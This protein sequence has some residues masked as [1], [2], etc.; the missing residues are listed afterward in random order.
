MTGQEVL[1]F[2]NSLTEE[3]LEKPVIFNIN[4]WMGYT[5]SMRVSKM[6]Y[7]QLY[8][9][10]EAEPSSAYSKEEL[11]DI[12]KNDYGFIVCNKGDIIIYG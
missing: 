8:D 12:L 10:D 2:L 9:E 4:D 6:D 1:K 3:Q 7:V 11:D 5:D